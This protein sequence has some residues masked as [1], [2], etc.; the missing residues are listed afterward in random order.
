MPTETRY[1]RS[2][3]YTDI[4][5]PSSVG[6]TTGSQTSGVVGDLASSN[7]VYKVFASGVGN[8]LDVEFLGA[9]SKDYPILKVTVELKT[10][11]NNIAGYIALY[12]Y[13]AG[14]Y[15]IAG[16]EGYYAISTS[17]SDTQYIIWVLD[18]RKYRGAP[19]HQWKIRLYLSHGSAFNDRDWETA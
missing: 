16:E 7:N 11:I 1:M 8:V 10:N 12:D 13:V 2:D 4:A 17:T 18:A 19:G 6:I 15:A 3:N 14:R 5:N 9:C